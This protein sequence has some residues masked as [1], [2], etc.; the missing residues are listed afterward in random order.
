MNDKISFLNKVFGKSKLQ[1]NQIELMVPCPYCKATKKLKMNIRLDSDLWHCW[2]CNEKG[3]SLGRLIKQKAPQ[4]VAEYY[5]RFAKNFTYNYSLD[6]SSEL[7]A[8]SLPDGFL[9]LMENL[10]KPAAKAVYHYAIARGLSDEDIWQNRIGYSE[11]W[12]LSRRLIIPS[13]DAD[14]NLNYWTARSIDPENKYRYINAKANK[15][16]LVFNEID[17]EYSK[18]VHLVE[19]PFDLLKTRH[20]NA[21]CLLG[22][23][24]SEA[25]LLFYKL[26][27]FCDSVILCLDSDAQSKQD[28]IAD[29]LLMYDKEVYYV[30]PPEDTDWGDTDRQTITTLFKSRKKYHRNSSLYRRI[31]AL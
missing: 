19:G 28:R 23:S 5:Q 27:A 30:D 9:L 15:K 16:T 2:V 25:S 31:N 22:S 14:G 17:L 11:E 4:K 12:S 7:D 24:L 26:V 1:N 20:V 29:S 10:N 3:R 8:V 13:F 18:P 21:T 6:D